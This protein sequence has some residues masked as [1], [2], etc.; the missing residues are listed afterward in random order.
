MDPLAH[1]GE[2]GIDP[3][4]HSGGRAMAFFQRRDAGHTLRTGLR[5][6]FA[7]LTQDTQ[8][9]LG[10]RNLLFQFGA[11]LFECAISPPAAL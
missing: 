7:A 6:I 11:S 2:Q 9:F 10:G 5:G 1:F 4:E 8:R 3:P